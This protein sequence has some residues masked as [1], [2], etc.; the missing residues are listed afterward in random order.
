[1]GGYSV[2]RYWRWIIGVAGGVAAVVAFVGQVQGLWPIVEHHVRSEPTLI[3]ATRDIGALEDPE[4]GSDGFQVAA[5]SPAGLDAKLRSSKDCDALMSAAK[6]AGAVDVNYVVEQL[7]IEGGSTHKIEIED[8]RA[9][10]LRRE[11]ALRGASIGCQSAGATEAIGVLFDLNDPRPVAQKI[12]RNAVEGGGQY[13]VFSTAGPYFSDGKV[14]G[15]ATGETQPF[16]VVGVTKDAYIEWEIEATV[17]DH[18]KLKTVTIDDNGEPFRVTGATAGERY[19]RYY[20]YM[21]YSSH[22]HMYAGPRRPV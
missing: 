14:V 5:R 10:V 9:K 8:M 19:K 13:D 20:E 4:G 7:M 11:P 15:L 12:V 17:Y 2:R 21:W 3:Q 6:Q 16:Q 1:M 22:P 18:G